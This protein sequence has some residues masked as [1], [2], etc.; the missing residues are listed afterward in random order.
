MEIT[1]KDV[2]S[3]PVIGATP[4]TS[5]AE[6]GQLFFRYRIGA[7]PVIDPRHHVVGIVSDGDLMRQIRLLDAS[8]H[9][10]WWRIG[11]SSRLDAAR[12]YASAHKFK[13]SELMSSPVVTVSEKLALSAALEIFEQ[14]EIKRAPVVREGKLV[15]MISRKDMLRVVLTSDD[16]NF[17]TAPLRLFKTTER[18]EILGRIA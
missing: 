9:L 11:G 15:G 8:P 4:D 16:R 2:M 13:A 18:S 3:A 5:A 14:K 7:V 1:V 6:I 10:R 17:P 12:Q